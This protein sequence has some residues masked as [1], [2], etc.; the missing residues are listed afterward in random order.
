MGILLP[1]LMY[2]LPDDQVA[3]IIEMLIDQ[4]YAIFRFRITT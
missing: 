2:V 4:V 3:T 1:L